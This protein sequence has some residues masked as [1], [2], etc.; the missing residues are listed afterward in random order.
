MRI[1]ERIRCFPAN[2]GGPPVSPATPEASAR[3]QPLVGSAA[4]LSRKK[5]Q[6]VK[7][8]NE[9]NLTS[10][11]YGVPIPAT[12]SRAPSLAGTLGSGNTAFGMPNSC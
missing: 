5:R 12:L 3:Q 4:N 7:T 11:K 6:K 9:V 8:R 2:N 10:D 1:S